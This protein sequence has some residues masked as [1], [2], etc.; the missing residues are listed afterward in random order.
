MDK[1]HIWLDITSTCCRKWFNVQNQGRKNEISSKMMTVWVLFED[2]KEE[3][4]IGFKPTIATSTSAFCPLFMECLNF[5]QFPPLTPGLLKIHFIII[6]ILWTSEHAE[7]CKP[8]SIHIILIQTPSTA[9]LLDPP[10][11]PLL[12]LFHWAAP[13]RATQNWELVREIIWLR[14]FDSIFL[15]LFC[16]VILKW[17]QW[18]RR[19]EWLLL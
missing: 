17:S 11:P 7:Q 16:R 9:W 13:N 2:F 8:I 5:P 12:H 4:Q 18:T 1:G 10:D 3:A 15:F 6:I 14:T 19:L